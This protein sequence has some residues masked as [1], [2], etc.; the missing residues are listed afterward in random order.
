MADLTLQS[1]NQ[2][3][4]IVDPR[5][6]QPSLYFM[7]YLH[8]RGGALTDVDA[9]L[10]LLR[11]S[12]LGKADKSTILTAGVGLSGGGDLSADRTF[13]LEN[14]SVTPGSYTNTNLTVDA[15]GR[16]T[17]AANGS[18]GGGGGDWPPGAWSTLTFPGTTTTVHGVSVYKSN[19]SFSIS[20]GDTVEIRCWG[21]KTL[22]G[23]GGLFV[24]NL[25]NAYSIVSQGDNNNV[26]YKYTGSSQAAL[27][28]VGSDAANDYTGWYSCWIQFSH[29]SGP[30]DSLVSLM[31]AARLPS[32]G[33][34]ITNTSWDI[35][36]SPLFG[37]FRDFDPTK[38]VVQMRVSS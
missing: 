1:L 32:T 11:E 25:T 23:D 9:Q 4:A 29:M 24:S 14:T 38:T 15:Q 3:Q 18:G 31:N 27:G 26:F 16:I 17:A 33:R 12:I 36:S 6:G 22:G 2:Q 37:L 8:D 5:T 30:N 35:S 34:N 13:D 19:E 10:E 7:R 21:Y 28:A 20:V